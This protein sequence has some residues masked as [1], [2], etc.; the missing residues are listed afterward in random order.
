[1]KRRYLKLMFFARSESD[2]LK[3]FL[4]ILLPAT[5]L[6]LVLFAW[7][8]A[9]ASWLID[10][11]RFH[12]S[13]HGRISC[14]E[15]HG[16]IPAT[17]H[18]DPRAVDKSLGDFFSLDQC[19]GCHATVVQDLDKGVH[20][21]RTVKDPKKYRDCIACHDPHYELSK[22]KLP[23]AFAPSKPVSLQCGACHANKTALPPLASADA[24]C[25]G[26]HREVRQG[27]PGAAREAAAFCFNCH[28]NS[29]EAALYSFP[30]IDSGTYE[31]STH[32]KLSC[33]AC[34]PESA[35]FGHARQ[36][37]TACLA[38]HTRHDEKVT[39]AAHL[40]VSC[41]ACHLQG[42]VPVARAGKIVWKV[43]SKPEDTARIHDMAPG[44]GESSCNRCHFSGNRL[45]AAAMVLPAKSILC[46]PCHSATFS[47]GD[48]TTIIS[49]LL[50]LVGVASLGTIWFS[51]KGRTNG[52]TAV[53]VP[54]ETTDAVIGAGLF[55]KVLY[56]LKIII[57]DVFLQ[58]RLFRQS[59][60]R[61]FIH[62][63]IF[64]P[65]VLRFLWGMTALLT[66]LWMPSASISWKMLDV[67]NPLHAFLFDLSGLMIL[68]GVI[69]TVL[70]KIASR[71]KVT[72]GLPAHD[73]PALFLLGTIVVVGFV[74]EGMRIAMTGAPSGSEYGL[75]GYGLSRLFSDPLVLTG[76]YGYVW[77]VH[78]IITGALVAYL[79]L[80]DLLHMILA[81]VVL[82]MNGLSRTGGRQ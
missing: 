9:E 81:P 5:T 16:Q 61:W 69:A 82:V 21:G 17:R 23:P 77:Y 29:R 31:A 62:S 8:R 10:Q 25:M 6:L 57:L 42:I 19:A 71:S 40:N 43:G 67:N 24:Q 51:A 13:V 35:R 66:S 49:L 32:S 27:E 33:F 7:S 80:S 39:H 70:R 76:I 79:P 4:R 41:E 38:C 36:K 52:E 59:K 68:A 12:V 45:G 58:R 22:A 2:E 55:S 47:V 3:L 1:M 78:A 26:C 30:A 28:G 20:A 44:R 46:M 60:S 14:L 50:F 75:I 73:W 18:P 37:L 53:L 54:H 63:L 56:V 64:W 48:P 74:L 72:S 11:G 15:C 65:I 34:H